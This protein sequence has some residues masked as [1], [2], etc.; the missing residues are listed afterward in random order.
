MDFVLRPAEIAAKIARVG[1]HAYLS[2][3]P[4]APEVL[5][6]PNQ[7]PDV[8][9]RILALLHDLTGVDF[10]HYKSNTLRRRI[11]RRMVLHHIDDMEGYVRLL[12]S[13]PAEQAALFQDFLI[14]VTTFFRSPQV[15][16]VLSERAY[17]KLFE[18]RSYR[19]PV[20]VWVIGCST[21]E[22]AYSI[23][24]SLAEFME[25]AGR[26]LSAQIFATD[27]NEASITMARAAV[28]SKNIENDVSPERLARFFTETDGHYRID[29]TIRDMCVFARHDALSSPPFSHIDL[30][31]CRNML[32]Y[33]E[34]ELQQ[35]LMPM[36]HFALNPRWLPAARQF[37]DDRR[38][39][40]SVR[41]RR[42]PQHAVLAQAG[43]WTVWRRRCRCCVGFRRRTVLGGRPLTGTP[44]L[45]RESD[46]IL[47]S[48]YTPPCVLVTR[49]LDI[50]QF[51][52]DTGPF[53]RARSGKAELEP[54]E[55]GARGTAGRTARRR[56]TS[57][58]RECHGPAGEPA[59]PIQRRLA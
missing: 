34:P 30:I 58:T 44:N 11:A 55:D 31:S 50:L 57:G 8:L 14:G 41:S 13:T 7:E 26:P 19:E 5:T 18:G 15:F 37:G 54:A 25:S 23:G 17:P 48:R 45:L 35:R 40:R 3:Q 28:Y 9:R 46:R 6:V 59:R 20:R 51:R 32:I 24:I 49:D 16:D 56:A 43:S 38:L 42:R 22:E 12:Q 33:L 27:L 4:E 10:T 47:L 29:Q 52:G 1:S 53:L 2:A 39:S 21:G 36:L